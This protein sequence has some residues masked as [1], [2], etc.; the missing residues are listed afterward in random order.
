MMLLFRGVNVSMKSGSVGVENGSGWNGSESFSS[1][2][3]N[4]PEFRVLGSD[5]LLSS[6]QSSSHYSLS[7]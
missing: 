7:F 6:Q 1:G 2:N 3:V 4:V 5:H